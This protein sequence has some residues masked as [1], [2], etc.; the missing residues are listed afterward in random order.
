MKRVTGVFL[1]V[2]MAMLGM[3]SILSGAEKHELVIGHIV[4]E[5]NTWHKASLKFKEIVE[6][7]SKGQ[8]KVTIY[9][10]N[11]LGS[12]VDVIQSILTGGG[13]DM[14]FTGESM[15]TYAEELGIIGMPYAITSETHMKKVLEG[16]VGKELDKLMLDAGMRVLGYFERGPRNITSKK[17]INTP[18]DLKG[19][20]IRVPASPMTVAA[21]DAMGAKPT[22]M[23]FGE[24]FTSLQQGVIDGQENPLAMIKT[25]AFYEVQKYVNVTEHLRAWVY[26][27]IGEEKFQ[28]LSPELQAVV[29]DAAKEMQKYEHELFLAEENALVDELKGK[30]MEFVTVDQKPFRDK[31]VE[32]SLKVL[33]PRQKALYDKIVAAE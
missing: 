27:T 1:A 23:A 28:S 19:F 7:K 14:T 21:F 18:D 29:A 3:S 5:N 33:T 15:Q 26:I 30:G 31:A 32:G 2:V 16:E 10:N 13:A 4:D 25:G 22:P 24:V 6:E 8:I 9:P 20:I 17:P 12:E 11:Q